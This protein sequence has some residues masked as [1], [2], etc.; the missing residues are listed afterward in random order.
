[1]DVLSWL[2]GIQKAVVSIGLCSRTNKGYIHGKARILFCR[3]NYCFMGYENWAIQV[4]L[5]RIIDCSNK[6]VYVGSTVKPNSP[7]VY[8]RQWIRSVNRYRRGLITILD[9]QFAPA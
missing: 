6:I 8:R 5:R 9:V 7:A 2:I 1:M 3:Q 4:Y